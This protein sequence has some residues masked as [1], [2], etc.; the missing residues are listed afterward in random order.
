MLRRTLVLSLCL[1][2]VFAVVGVS[3]SSAKVGG[4]LPF[5]IMPI[6]GYTQDTINMTCNVSLDPSDGKT[7]KFECH[8]NGLNPHPP[9]DKKVLKQAEGPG[10]GSLT[11]YPD[12]RVVLIFYGSI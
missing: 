7:G 9:K 11:L 10:R 12:G 2:A 4:K 1:A 6:P 3:A 5:T 8:Q